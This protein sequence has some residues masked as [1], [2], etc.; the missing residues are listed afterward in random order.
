LIGHGKQERPEDLAK[1]LIKIRAKLGL[2]QTGMANALERHGVKATR[3]YVS[4]Y[5]LGMRIPGL[6]TIVAYAEIAGIST[7]KLINDKLDL[8]AKYK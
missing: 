8:P 7:D 3:G 4:R 6:L 5:E 1:K 2:S